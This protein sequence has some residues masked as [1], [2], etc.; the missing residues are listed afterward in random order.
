MS[1]RE[2]FAAA[3]ALAGHRYADLV[4]GGRCCALA[5]SAAR[6][7]F[8]LDAAGRALVEPHLAAFLRLRETDPAAAA[9]RAWAAYDALEAERPRAFPRQE[10]RP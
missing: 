1:A 3:M 4:Q 8:D 7:F 2:H 5:T 6:W 9:A 10:G